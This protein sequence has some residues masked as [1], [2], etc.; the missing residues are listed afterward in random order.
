MNWVL[1]LV[2]ISWQDRC[3]CF[4]KPSLGL[5]CKCNPFFLSCIFLFLVSAIMIIS[6][7]I[8]LSR[9]FGCCSFRAGHRIIH[10][11]SFA[12]FVGDGACPGSR[13]QLSSTDPRG[14]LHVAYLL[15]F[16]CEHQSSSYAQSHSQFTHFSA[17]SFHCGQLL[18]CPRTRGSS[19][20]SNRAMHGSRTPAIL[21]STSFPSFRAA[22]FDSQ[23]TFL[24]P[25]TSILDRTVIS[26]LS[27]CCQ[28]KDRV[29]H[30]GKSGNHELRYMMQ[31][32]E[33][34]CSRH[35]LAIQGRRKNE[36]SFAPAQ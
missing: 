35:F 4:E 30:S 36:N 9:R 31:H 29:P 22:N 3:S 34:Y 14:M 19:P 12:W 16:L 11:R 27:Q 26:I 33:D 8:R 28:L 15:I 2:T 17:P 5:F 1:A 23:P 21:F 13:R 24:L 32:S 7:C 20:S 25:G 6:F 10:L 18:S